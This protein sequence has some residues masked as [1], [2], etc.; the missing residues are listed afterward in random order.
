MAKKQVTINEELLRG[1]MA[2]DVPVYGKDAPKDVI[3][4]EESASETECMQEKKNDT[5]G[6]DAKIVVRQKKR[7]NESG[8]YRQQFLKGGNVQSRQQAYIS[9]DNY[10]FIR[11]FLSI[12]A[13]GVSMSKYI[14]DILTAHMEQYREEINNLYH[15]QIN[16]EPLY[17]K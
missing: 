3:L 5:V 4:D 14:D 11:K 16:N 9:L 12:V 13:P 10:Q 1:I 2:G 7:Q 6:Y 17:K 8:S 15:N